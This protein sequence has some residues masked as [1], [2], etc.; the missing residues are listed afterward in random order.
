GSYRVL[1]AP[2]TT[3]GEDRAALTKP[4]AYRV[5]RLDCERLSGEGG[6]ALAE[7]TLW[8]PQTLSRLEVAAPVPEVGR[9]GLLPLRANATFDAGEVLKS[10]QTVTWYAHVKNYGAADAPPV[11]AEWRL[12]G[13]PLRAISLPK[14]PRFAETEATLVLPWDAARHEIELA[15]DPKNEVAE[16]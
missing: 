4:R 10:G 1:S 13:K 15:V 9:G 14:V 7:W 12:D 6:V 3:S 5:Y 16:T 2:R 8:S 11:K